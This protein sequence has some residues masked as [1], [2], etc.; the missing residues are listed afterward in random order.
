L[1]AVG[2]SAGAQPVEHVTD[3][4]PGSLAWGAQFGSQIALDGEFMAVAAPQD[5]RPDAI[6]V[7]SIYLFYR[8]DGGDDRWGQVFRLWADFEQDSVAEGIAELALSGSTLAVSYAGEY[9]EAVRIYHGQV[10]PPMSWSLAKALTPSLCGYHYGLSISLSNERLAIADPCS[11]SIRMFE[12]D[13]GGY[14]NWGEVAGITGPGF[15]LVSPHAIELDGD[16]L[17][18][19]EISSG[20]AAV[21]ELLG[22]A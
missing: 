3:I 19:L 4:S 16:R 5:D 14:D 2:T 8:D 17:V 15:S 6:G 12:R 1:T 18:A 20:S 11:E 10:D 21:W 22:D 7:G 13:A 9:P